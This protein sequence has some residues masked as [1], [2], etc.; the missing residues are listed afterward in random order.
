MTASYLIVE[1][2]ALL[3]ATV[4]QCIFTVDLILNTKK[5]QKSITHPTVAEV[6]AV[7]DVLVPALVLVQEAVEQGAHKRTRWRHH[8]NE[9]RVFISYNAEQSIREVYLNSCDK[10]AIYEY[11]VFNSSINHKLC[12]ARELALI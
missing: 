2:E 1:A 4:I 10:V 9:H 6:T 5:R 11:R 7:A 8:A 12:F 3:E